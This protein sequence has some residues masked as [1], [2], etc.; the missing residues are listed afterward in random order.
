MMSLTL[1]KR[2]RRSRGPVRGDY[3]PRVIEFLNREDLRRDAQKF[4][5]EFKAD[6]EQAMRPPRNAG[7]QKLQD[8]INK[9]GLK[10]E[11]MIDPLDKPTVRGMPGESVL[12]FRDEKFIVQEWTG[13]QGFK[14]DLYW[15]LDMAL[16]TG[17][18]TTLKKCRWCSKFFASYRR[19]VFSC[20]AKCN[21]KFHND[22]GK[23]TKY[24]KKNYRD[25][26][27]EK[28]NI[29]RELRGKPLDVIMKK[30]GLTKL[31]LIREGIVEE[32]QE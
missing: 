27:Q 16:Q 30:S 28:L 17:E 1:T 21:T 11:L 15:D 5:R 19:G 20:S 23:K 31:A 26:K 13:G 10:R 8:R 14:K 32:Q 24:F 6:I 2:A 25:K 29:A 12:D 7:L 3:I 22:Q 18:F 4:H 9:A